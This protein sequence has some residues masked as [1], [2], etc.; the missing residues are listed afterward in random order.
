MQCNA[1][2]GERPV[3]HITDEA[4]QSECPACIAALLAF[5]RWLSCAYVM[6]ALHFEISISAAHTPA[7]QSYLLTV[8]SPLSPTCSAP[9]TLPLPKQ[10]PNMR[11]TCVR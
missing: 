6:C 11:E 2:L 4:S 1:M 5:Y 8:A 9:S 7:V 10:E 3:C